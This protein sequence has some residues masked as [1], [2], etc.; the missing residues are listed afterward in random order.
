[1]TTPA[2]NAVRSWICF[3]IGAREH[4][5]VPRAISASGRD[6]RLVTDVWAT[7]HS[8]SWMPKAWRQ[9]SHPDVP[10]Q[11]V[12]SWNVSAFALRLKTQSRTTWDRILIEDQWFQKK[13]A[14][15]LR[16]LVAQHS[17]PPIVF[18]YSYAALRI[19]ETARELGCPTVLGQID[20]G[21]VEVRLVQKLEAA[22]G[23]HN[24]NWP[25]PEYWDNWRRECELADRIVVNSEWSRQ[26]LEQELGCTDKLERISLA[27]ER[28]AECSGDGNSQTAISSTGPSTTRV[29]DET[30]KHSPVDGPALPAKFTQDRQLQVLFLGQ[31][32]LRKGIAEL[33]DAVRN[34][35]DAP[36]HWTI[37]GSG[38]SQLMEELQRL[39]SVTVAGQVVRS[40]AVRF[41][42]TSDVFILP[43]HSDGFAL[44]QLEAAAYGLPII[45]S[46]HC[47]EVVDNEQNGLLLDEVSGGEIAATVQQLLDRP[48]MLAQFRETQQQRPVYGVD[49][50]AHRLSQLA[51]TLL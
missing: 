42:Q 32:I 26:A 22:Y 15:A 8:R 14:T 18:A 13:A 12:T 31:V 47:G 11:W 5:A 38:T 10:S 16:K 9:R 25:T 36:V 49:A 7:A 23:L 41:Y 28:Q 2:D 44:T 24:A 19:L 30:G 34:L 40:E 3:Q 33:I 50:L 48:E 39:P 37:V 17:Q 35:Q 43:T 21:P 45:A 29:Q 6:V 46:R 27:Y 51:D 20:P 4:Y 1:M